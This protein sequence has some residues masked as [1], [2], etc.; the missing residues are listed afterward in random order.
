MRRQRKAEERRLVKESEAFLHGEFA[1]SG[2][3]ADAP[4]PV[5]AWINL[6]AHGTEQQLRQESV[7][8][9]G[10]DDWH[11]ARSLLAAKLLAAIGSSDTSLVAIQRYVLVPLEFEIISSGTA[12][13]SPARLVTTVLGALADTDRRTG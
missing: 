11:R 3:P 4:T 2:V 13:W 8:P 12:Y 9:L 7:A 5:W 1:E 10:S 6:L